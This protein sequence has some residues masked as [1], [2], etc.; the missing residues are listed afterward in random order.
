MV[1]NVPLADSGD[2]W[3][4]RGALVASLVGPLGASLVI[5][6]L[7]LWLIAPARRAFEREAKGGVLPSFREAMRFSLLLAAYTV[8]AGLAL[9]LIAIFDPLAP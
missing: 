1:N 5:V 8:P 9:A 4:A 6:N 7:A 2:S 3:L